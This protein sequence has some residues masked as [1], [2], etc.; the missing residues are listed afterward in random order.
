MTDRRSPTT[1]APSSVTIVGGGLIGLCCAH[2]LSRAGLEVTVL[3]RDRVGSGASRGNAGEVC[4]D[5]V[6]PLAAPGKVT[7]ALRGLHRP[8]SALYVHPGPSAELMRFLAGFARRANRR[9]HDR[10]ARALAKLAGE[11]FA[12]F[13]ELEELG[14]DG[15]ADKSGFL[16]AFPER[17][18]AVAARAAF[19]RLGAPLAGSGVLDR[20]GMADAEPA[21]S[22]RARAGFLVEDQWSLD[23]SLF[24]DRLAARLRAQ[25]VRVVEG[26]RVTDVEEYPGGV[27]VHTT[28][29]SHHADRTV[30]AAGVRS[31]E[32]LRGLGT[33]VTLFP[34][35]GYSFS[36]RTE[37]PL[38]RLVHLGSAH[39][40][41]TPLRDRVRVA[42]TMEF[43]SDH[44]RF[45][46]GRVRAIAA[47][48]GPYLPEV[49]WSARQE[50]WVG[51][52]PMTPDGLPLIG[53]VPGTAR[54][55]TACG[56]N[57]L[58]LM[59]APAT[60]ALVTTLVQGDG[61]PAVAAPFAPARLARG[62][63][64]FRR[65]TPS[66]RRSGG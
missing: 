57:M 36:V 37:R 19:A 11:T 52:R 47:A 16:F 62:H 35:K 22:A 49:D 32:L 23:P 20:A 24:V 40:V 39:V 51:S 10:G 26:A 63:G 33:A 5:L 38:R 44:D 65:R 18:A 25:G 9:D 34:G 29:G 8:D 41:L 42:G 21:L 13:E 15:Q 30:I 60:G 66:A 4:P 54:V 59:L 6:E 55:L 45:R 46:A 14:V 2:Y 7:E 64:P 56:H 3:E 61:M 27:A 17:A 43:D 58:G 53:P 31:R 1:A 28:A 48:A 50:E 12:L